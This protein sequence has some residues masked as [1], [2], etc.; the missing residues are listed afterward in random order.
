MNSTAQATSGTGG[1]SLCDHSM[2]R[3]RFV[4]SIA[5]T[6]VAVGIGTPAWGGES[7]SGDM[8]YRTMGKT[9]EKI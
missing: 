5:A 6:G 7:R 1:V 8:L 2:T 3:R 9:G 4:K